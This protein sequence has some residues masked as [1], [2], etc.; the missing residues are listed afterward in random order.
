MQLNDRL[1]QQIHHLKAFAFGQLEGRKPSQ[2]CMQV[3]R[4]L[5]NGGSGFQIPLGL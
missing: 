2:T 3:Q 4:A 1:W 5:T